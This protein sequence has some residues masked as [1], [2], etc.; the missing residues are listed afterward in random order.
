MDVFKKGFSIAREG[1]VGA[2]EK[3]KQ[4]VTEAAEKTKEGADRNS[5]VLM[6]T[7]GAAL[8]WGHIACH[9]HIPYT[10]HGRMP[11]CSFLKSYLLMTHTLCL[12][13]LGV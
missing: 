9:L 8:H 13:Q 12:G 2:V 7:E 11:G 10:A 1:V 5:T 4:G 3:T 6:E